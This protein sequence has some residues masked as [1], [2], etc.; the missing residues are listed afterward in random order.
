MQ[1]VISLEGLGQIL[2][3][4]AQRVGLFHKGLDVTIERGVAF[5]KLCAEVLY[6]VP[7]RFEQLLEGVQMLLSQAVA[8][9]A[10]HLHRHGFEFCPQCLCLFAH[11]FLGMLLLGFEL[12]LRTDG[13][14]LRAQ[15]TYGITRRKGYYCDYYKIHKRVGGRG[16]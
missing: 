3:L 8:L 6:V 4:A 11:G 7:K 13:G 14:T 5:D 1:L 2:G 12:C 15:H 10:H 16:G 9:R